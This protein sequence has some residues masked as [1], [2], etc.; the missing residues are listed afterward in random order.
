MTL[1]CNIS[2]I[3]TVKNAGIGLYMTME[4]LKV[5]RT[6]LPY[7]VIIV[8][9]GSIDGCCDFLMYYHFPSPLKLLKGRPGIPSRNLAAAHASGQVII[10]CN[11]SLYF[12]DDCLELL[13][14]RIMDEEVEAQ[15]P[16]ITIQAHAGSSKGLEGC[17]GILDS[18]SMYPLLY[19]GSDELC[20]LSP[21]CW[22]VNLMCFRDLG[23]VEEGFSSKELETAEFSIRLWL[24]GG[25]CRIQE[26]AT[27]TAVYRPNFSYETESYRW[28][29]DLLLLSHLH[30]SD[31]NIHKCRQL[32][33]QCSGPEVL[34]HE[35][36]IVRMAA[37]SRYKYASRRKREDSWLFNRFKVG[38]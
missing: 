19:E 7:E 12:E 29:D 38:V 23:G 35:R 24:S 6:H 18:F 5:T 33:L 13:S 20:W 32:V 9:E 28:E 10:F 37:S 34:Q 31:E 30:L 26:E 14:R 16:R 22:A 36:E 2:I 4:S 27:L 3:F 1:N 17:G 8:D 15:S 21:D 25:S 11:S